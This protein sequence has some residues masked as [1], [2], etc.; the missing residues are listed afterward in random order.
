VCE[1]NLAF[2]AVRTV[3]NE[4]VDALSYTGPEIAQ[5]KRLVRKVLDPA[6]EILAHPI[7]SHENMRLDGL[8]LPITSPEHIA[9]DS[10]QNVAILFSF[11]QGPGAREKSG[12]SYFCEHLES[13][14]WKTILCENA[15]K[16]DAERL[17]AG[18]INSARFRKGANLYLFIGNVVK[19]RRSTYI[20]P[21]SH[22]IT[23]S[24]RHNRVDW[25]EEVKFKAFSI[26]WLQE[27]LGAVREYGAPP[28]FIIVESDVSSGDIDG[29][30]LPSCKQRTFNSMVVRCF[31]DRKPQLASVTQDMENR[32][33]GSQFLARLQYLIIQK[34]ID[35]R[36]VLMRIHSGFEGERSEYSISL[37]YDGLR[38]NYFFHPELGQARS[39]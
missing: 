17:I 37:D 26:D 9:L 4:A 16:I 18:N 31:R 21:D 28:V 1:E 27:Q 12:M 6:A 29:N 8:C 14:H 34:G 32:R 22:E 30:L 19:I 3:L 25:E 38:Q 5:G 33:A 36:D 35:V 15:K 20:M 24:F 10:Y 23:A 13:L 11:Q 7:V 2:A 39:H